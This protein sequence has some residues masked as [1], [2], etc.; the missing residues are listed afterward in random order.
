MDDK[1]LS[2]ESFSNHF[3]FFFSVR[4]LQKHQEKKKQKRKDFD[5]FIFYEGGAALLAKSG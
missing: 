4:Y 1:V 5:L 2:G 3:T